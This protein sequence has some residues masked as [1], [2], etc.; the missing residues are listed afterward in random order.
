V[1]ETAS[2]ERDLAGQ[3]GLTVDRIYCNG[4]YPERFA[5]DEIERVEATLP[6]AGGGARAALRAAR[7]EHRR[8]HDQRLQLARLEENCEAPVSSLP[9]LFEPELELEEIEMLIEELAL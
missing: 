7:T 9:F 8:A 5:D 6:E 1:N 3:V 4:L 2:L